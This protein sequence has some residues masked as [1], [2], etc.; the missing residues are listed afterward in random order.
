[1]IYPS[2]RLCEYAA[3][4]QY[5]EFRAKAFVLFLWDTVSDDDF[6]NGAG[7]DAGDGV[8]AENS[9][10]EKG[11]DVGSTFPLYKLGGAGNRVRCISEIIDD[12]GNS[13][14]DISH[15]HHGGV[16]AVSD[17]SRSTFLVC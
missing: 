12:N 16:L 13:A 5:F 1:M 10:C 8:A 9:V 15:K 17:A 4:L 7:V 2:N 6:V 11:I 14:S 3:N